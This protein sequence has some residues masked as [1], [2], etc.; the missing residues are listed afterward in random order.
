MSNTIERVIAYIEN[1]LFE[2]V[3]LSKIS[4]EVNYSISHLHR[5]F[6]N[7]TGLN[8]NQ[9]IL[10]RRLSEA[11]VLITTTNHSMVDISIK[12]GFDNDKYF[13]RMFKKKFNVTPS[14]LRKE[15]IYL[16]L[17][18]RLNVESRKTKMRFKSIDEFKEKLLNCRT[19]NELYGF[20]ANTDGCVLSKQN[21]SDVEFILVLHNEEEL[22]VE[23]IQYNI[24]MISGRDIM[25]HI[26]SVGGIYDVSIIDLNAVNDEI[27]FYFQDIN[28][29]KKSRVVLV[30][31]KEN[32]IYFGS[33]L[34]WYSN[35]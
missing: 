24:N 9:Y 21:N 33:R 29:K 23:I 31:R 32:K 5:I 27:E 19:S 11:S 12:C 15:L 25:K 22:G 4:S 28:T 30:P 13:S 26:Y 1:N 34:G 8:I 35:V 7:A 6:K 14:S 10:Y 20:V 16:N 2:E 3:N 18:T 17:T